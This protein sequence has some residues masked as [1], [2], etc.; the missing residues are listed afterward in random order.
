MLTPFVLTLTAA[1]SVPVL[2]APALFRAL[3]ELRYP[4]APPDQVDAPDLP[5]DTHTDRPRLDKAQRSQPGKRANIA[6]RPA[7]HS[8]RERQHP[9]RR[10]RP[11]EA[12]TPG[13]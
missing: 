5:A 11:R 7:L 6:P 9:V 13:K 12:G 8:R 4:A 10:C 2:V 1:S 3:L